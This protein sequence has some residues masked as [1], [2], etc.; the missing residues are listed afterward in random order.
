MKGDQFT[1]ETSRRGPSRWQ[2][3]HGQGLGS[4]ISVEAGVHALGMPEPSCA[5]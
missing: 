3:W 1:Q 4:C 2:E 5:R